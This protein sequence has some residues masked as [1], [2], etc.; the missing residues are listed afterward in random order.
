MLKRRHG[1]RR[2]RY[3]GADGMARWVGLDVIANNLV[4]TATFV[5]AIR[6]QAGSRMDRRT[7]SARS[8]LHQKVA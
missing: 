3:H 6:Q 1:L 5:S 2:R 8:F 4:S 7:V